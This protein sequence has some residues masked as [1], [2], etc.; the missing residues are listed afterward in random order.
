M[1]HGSLDIAKV[2]SDPECYAI[3]FAAPEASSTGSTARTFTGLAQV[4]E[5]LQQAGVPSD[6]IRPALEL[7]EHDGTAR[8]E[9]IVLEARELQDLGLQTRSG[10]KSPTA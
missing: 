4:D 7:A 6:R 10:A 2:G 5:F 8:I 3:T 1:R 9:N